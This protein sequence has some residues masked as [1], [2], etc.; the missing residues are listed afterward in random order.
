M[1]FMNRT[2]RWMSLRA[3][4]L[5]ATVAVAALDATAAE[6]LL[7]TNGTL[8]TMQP[9][10]PT[11][12]VGYLAVGEDGKISAIGKGAPPASLAAQ[13]TLDAHGKLIAP[14]I[15]LRTATSGRAPFADWR[16]ISTCAAG[17]M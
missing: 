4:C 6:R 9:G 7:I 1:R 5:G 17:S 8:L 15:R 3:L 2:K 10:E 11:A 12:Y 14:G 13:A 16:P